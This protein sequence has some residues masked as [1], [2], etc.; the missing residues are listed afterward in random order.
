MKPTTNKTTKAASSRSP[1]RPNL[2]PQ[3]AAAALMLP[4]VV[5]A[6][7][8]AAPTGYTEGAPDNPIARSAISVWETGVVSYDPAPG[9]SS[10]FSNPETGLASLGDLSNP[11]TTSSSPTIGLIGI[12]APGSITLSFA[13]PITDGD[14]ADFAV[15][16]NGF[17]YGPAGSLFAELAYVEVSSDGINFV[18]FESISLNTS[19]SAGSGA[20]AGY[21]MTNVYNLAGKSAANWGTPFDLSELATQNL[22][23]DGI[24]DLSAINYVRLVDVVGSGSITDGEGAEIPGIA[25]DSLGN[26]ILDNWV[27]SGSGGFDYV[28]LPTGAIGVIH[29]V[30]E[31]GTVLLSA[32]FAGFACIKRRR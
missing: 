7:I 4:S 26:P 10:S 32:V 2:T 30:P 29:S 14:G 1:F 9:V 24:V 31:L 5:K 8:Y 17:T 19:T 11:L 3:A 6:G 15:F 27:T 18:R 21:D 23:I 13:N 22:V 12:D 25:K 28:G 20:F 16:E